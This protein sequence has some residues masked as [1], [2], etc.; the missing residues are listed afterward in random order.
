MNGEK[1]CVLKDIFLKLTPSNGLK[2]KHINYSD[3][4]IKFLAPYKSIEVCAL[5][6][7]RSYVKII[8]IIF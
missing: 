1:N 5:S 7:H 4:N 3:R 6:R 8:F 2:I